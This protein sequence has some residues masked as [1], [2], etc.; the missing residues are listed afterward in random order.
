MRD[1]SAW[2]LPL[3]DIFDFLPDPVRDHGL[4]AAHPRPLVSPGKRSGPAVRFL[5]YV[6]GG[7]L[8]LS[9]A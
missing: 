9:R 6:T 4:R 7:R 2:P 3:S 1:H 8:A 5:S